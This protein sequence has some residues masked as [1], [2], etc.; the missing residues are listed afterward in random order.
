MGPAGRVLRGALAQLDLSQE[1]KDKVKAVVEAEKPG[2]ETLGARHR[3]DALALRDVAAAA[4][5]D[6]KAVGEAYLKVSQNRVA[7]KAAREKV[8]VKIEA[9]LTSA[10]K[11][12]FEGYI[13]AAK[14]AARGAARRGHA[15]GGGR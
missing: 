10:Q 1:Q 9:L 8:L 7:A 4:Q 14:D 6:P 3:A 12:K 13:Q 11:A 2:L 5:P 15:A